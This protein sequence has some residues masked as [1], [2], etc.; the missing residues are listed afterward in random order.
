MNANTP[1][2]NEVTGVV[3]T[4]ITNALNEAFHRQIRV[5]GEPH[6]EPNASCN[7]L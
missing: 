2:A 5:V 3:Y 1:K 6:K 4:P 7:R